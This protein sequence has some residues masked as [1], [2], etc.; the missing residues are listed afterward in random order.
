MKTNVEKQVAA[1]DQVL[2]HCNALGEMYNPSKE[3]LQVTALTSLLTSAR[4]SVKAV[5][6][7][8]GNLILAINHRQRTFAPLPSIATRIV[9]SLTAADAPPEL[10]ADM[11]LYRDK[12]R[13]QA[14]AGRKTKAPP[15]D[16]SKVEP[17]PARTSRGP[18]SQLDYNTKI[19]NFGIMI[20]MLKSDFVYE[21]NTVDIT[22]ER[23]TA[24]LTGME[25]AHQ[26]VRDA[27][28][29]LSNARTSRD[30]IVYGDTGVYGTARR[31]KKFVSSALGTTSVEARKINGIRFSKAR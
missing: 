15:D 19:R 1:F 28:L 31:V 4:E 12:F 26:A 8:K 20:G 30:R 16:S 11:K 18:L 14:S 22:L 6:T 3:S 25:Q 9:H 7:A 29:A 21:P 17:I 10:I 5:D 27:E 24:I 23:L 13:S 2:G